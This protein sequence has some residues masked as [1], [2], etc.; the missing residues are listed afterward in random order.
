ML[1]PVVA[2]SLVSGVPQPIGAGVSVGGSS[3]GVSS[4]V[5][6]PVG[7]AAGGATDSLSSRRH[8]G[9]DS[10]TGSGSAGV[11]DSKVSVWDSVVPHEVGVGAAEAIVSSTAFGTGAVSSGRP[12]PESFSE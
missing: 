6:Q 3:V 5:P 7:E 8:G 12:L 2:G 11:T 1:Q 9:V 10:A 4:G